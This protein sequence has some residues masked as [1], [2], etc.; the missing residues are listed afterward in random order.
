MTRLSGHEL[1][2]EGAPY[3]GKKRRISSY[4][5]GVSGEGRA[6]C[7]CGALSD[8]LSSANKRKAWHRAHKEEIRGAK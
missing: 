6:L 3:D 5:G 1:L 4:Y 7:S 2:S 8:F